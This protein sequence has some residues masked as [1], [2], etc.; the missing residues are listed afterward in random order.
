MT[1]PNPLVRELIDAIGAEAVVWQAEDLLVYEYDA[2][3]DRGKPEAIALPATTDDVVALMRICNRHNV[4]ITPRGAG[5]GLSGGALATRGGVV[6]G[7]NRMRRILEIDVENK[8]ARVQPGV[9][10]LDLGMSVE[11]YGL[12]YA[13]DPSSQ[14]ACTIGGN[15]AENA[16][17]PH[18]LAWGTTTNHVLELTLVTPDG[19]VQ[20]IGDATRDQPGYDLVGCVVGSE[21]TVGIVTEALVRLVPKPTSVRTLL[22]IY[23]SVREASNAVSAVVASGV[24]PAALE[25]ID[26]TTIAAIEPV[27][28]T[29]FPLDAEAVLLV[30]VDGP[31]SQVAAE[32]AIVESILRRFEPRE[33]R[34][35]TDPEE[36]ERLWAGR[37]GA[38][39]RWA[40]SCPT[41]TCSTAWYRA[42]S[43]PTCS[44]RSTKSPNATACRSRTCSTP[45]T[46]TCTPACCSTSANPARPSVCLRP[47]A[48]SCASASIPAA[49][50]TGEHGVGHEKRDYLPW[51]FTE[52]DMTAMKGL[53]LAFG[54]TDNF[55][56]CKIFPSGHG[57]GE[58]SG[59]NAQQAI[60]RFGPKAFV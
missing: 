31:P 1:Q 54:A 46:A 25:M 6:F 22:A 26:K 56:P 33:I 51:I 8:T 44:T 3:I 32:G 27:L 48:R 47:A 18:T 23:D 10:N 59:P 24:V 30:E 39:G 12:A 58:A 42:P 19:E 45:A 28:H 13:P 50:I 60:A 7:M 41:T 14:R 40:R 37:K 16:G 15:V 17:G 4:P 9:V 2:T 34:S 21:G 43:C 49:P 55:N 5:T 57:C 29:G 53:R 20:R 11:P 38:I 52:A 36:R 35:A